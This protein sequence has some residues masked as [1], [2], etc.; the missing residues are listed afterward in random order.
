MKAVH[1]TVN[2]KACQYGLDILRNH[3]DRIKDN[4]RAIKPI[5]EVERDSSI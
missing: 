3:I 5:R 2:E 4:A 1:L